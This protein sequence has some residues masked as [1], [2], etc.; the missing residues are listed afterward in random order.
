MKRSGWFT[1]DEARALMGR[2]VECIWAHP[3]NYEGS[4]TVHVGDTG[5]IDDM[6]EIE[7]WDGC[8]IVVVTWNRMSETWYPEVEPE[9]PQLMHGY[10]KQFYAC[11][12]LL[13]P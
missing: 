4:G 1:K 6:A 10:G 5:S 11:C 12:R 2:K 8:W 7:T 13:D 9:R 3:A